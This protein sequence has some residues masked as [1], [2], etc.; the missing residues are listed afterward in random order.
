MNRLR[1]R[2]LDGQG[3]F[4]LIELMIVVIVIG[5]LA[6]IALPNYISMRRNSVR[7]SCI[8]NQRNIA[9][10]AALYSNETGVSDATINV[11]V[12]QAGG[13]VST[14]SSECPA[15]KLRDNDD[16]MVTISN[17]RVTS[18]TCTVSPSEHHWS[19]LN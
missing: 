7:S 1:E 18:I 6:G 9:H 5:I 14:A 17:N 2:S 19:G 3:G 13:Y 10:G 11:L 15:S 8:A 12:L 16:Y 4:T